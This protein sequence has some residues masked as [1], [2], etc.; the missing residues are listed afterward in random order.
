M[1]DLR[2]L[3]QALYELSAPRWAK[4]KFVRR[5]KEPEELLEAAKQQMEAIH[6]RNRERATLAITQKNNLLQMV[7]DLERKIDRLA[8]KAQRAEERG[9]IDIARQILKEREAYQK[10]LEVSRDSVAEAEALAQEIKDSIFIEQDEVRKKTARLLA[11]KTEW[12][13]SQITVEMERDIRSWFQIHVPGFKSF[14]LETVRS[15]VGIL[16]AVIVVLLAIVG[17]LLVV[18]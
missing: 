11:L 1:S 6:A 4:S 15:L 10:S 14:E 16:L 18:R 13:A 8:E 12:Q 7:E 17:V 9:D 5:T 2:R 3:I